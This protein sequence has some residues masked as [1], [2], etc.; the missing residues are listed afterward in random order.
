MLGT[1]HVV[2]PSSLQT[3]IE[4]CVHD[5]TVGW[6]WLCHILT[7]SLVGHLLY[8]SMLI[9]CRYMGVVYG[10]YHHNVVRTSILPGEKQSGKLLDYLS[11]NTV[12]FSNILYPLHPYI[13]RFI[14]G[15]YAFVTQLLQ[16]KT[17][18]LGLCASV[19]VCN[20]TSYVCKNSIF[21]RNVYC[22]TF[23]NICHNT[24]INKTFTIFDNH[25]KGKTWS[26][27]AFIRDL[28]ELRD[29]VI[30]NANK[31]IPISDVKDILDYLCCTKTFISNCTYVIFLY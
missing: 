21:I 8:Y 14:E 30:R 27:R 22:I 6:T 15:S 2:G 17:E 10:I 19:A 25:E 18:Y 1:C 16:V 12:A 9:V 24:G 23:E 4:A 28:I 26:C 29:S 20:K 7:T 31:Y 3:A 13:P 11:E 5:L